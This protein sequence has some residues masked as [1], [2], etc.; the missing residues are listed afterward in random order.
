[1]N[2]EYQR[3][4][5]IL[6]ALAL[7]GCASANWATANKR[8]T[9]LPELSVQLQGATGP[10]IL[11]VQQ[12]AQ[13]LAALRGP[14]RDEFEDRRLA[15]AV[16]AYWCETTAGLSTNAFTFVRVTKDAEGYAFISFADDG[17]LLGAGGGR[18]DTPWARKWLSAPEEKAANNR[19][20]R[21]RS[22]E[23]QTEP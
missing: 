20:H 22:P 6:A 12:T 11:D 8:I 18:I 2:K 21:T 5:A 15:P 4:G 16:K 17:Y 19:L 3:V 23:R 10:V 1:M 7:S 13:L 9:F 14:V